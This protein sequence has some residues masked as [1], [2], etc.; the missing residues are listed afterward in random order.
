MKVLITNDDGIYA[1]GLSILTRWARRALHEVI[2]VAPDANRSGQSMA[3]TLHEPLKVRMVR[4][5]EWA[6]SGTP[7]D[8]VRIAHSFLGVTPDLVLSGINHGYNLGHD[9]HTSGT[10]GAARLAS[11]HGVPAGALS[12]DPRDWD[13][14]ARLLEHHGSD[15]LAAIRMSSQGD[16]ISVNFPSHGGETLVECRLSRPRYYDQLHWSQLD[17]TDTH[18]VLI[19]FLPAPLTLEDFDS[20]AGLVQRGI[21]TLT[22][23]SSDALSGLTSDKSALSQ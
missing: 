8:C 22:R 3:V 10:V 7:A 12:A 15:I 21:T 20:D 13:Q 5:D 4:T 6:V 1:E 9:V 2:V 14:V 16:V 11:I 19:D 18:T 17:D 23:L